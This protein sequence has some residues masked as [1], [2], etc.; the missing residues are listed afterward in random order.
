MT[1]LIIQHMVKMSNVYNFEFK[2]ILLEIES[3]R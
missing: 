2:I 3:L 1:L